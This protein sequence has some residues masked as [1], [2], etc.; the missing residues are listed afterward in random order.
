LF[1]YTALACL[2]QC[3]L[4]TSITFCSSSFYALWAI[5]LQCTIPR[6]CSSTPAF[7][8]IVHTSILLHSDNPCHLFFSHSS[9][10]CCLCACNIHNASACSLRAKFLHNLSAL[11]DHHC[12]S[13]A[14]LVVFH[15]FSITVCYTD[16]P[17]PLWQFETLCLLCDSRA[18]LLYSSYRPQCSSSCQSPP[19]TSSFLLRIPRDSSPPLSIIPKCLRVLWQKRSVVSGSYTVS[20]YSSPPILFKFTCTIGLIPR[21]LAFISAFQ[22]SAVRHSCDHVSRHSQ[23]RSSKR[24][25]VSLA[26]SS[27]SR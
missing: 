15:S 17:Q 23:S 24:S 3:L 18:H 21:D 4:H 1:C 6:L 7:F 14:S 16:I 20:C 22:L 5:S 25:L 19:Q 13:S 26:L 2:H 10:L 9:S 27:I 12:D 11:F 8:L